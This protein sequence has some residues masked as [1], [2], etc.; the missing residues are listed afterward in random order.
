MGR[1]RSS[2]IFVSSRYLAGQGVNGLLSLSAPSSTA[3]P[4]L[5]GCASHYPV[6]FF[7]S[8]REGGKRV[9]GEGR[10]LGDR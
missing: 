8:C 4:S 1:W 3:R 2:A 5:S 6:S 7:R 9:L 10:L